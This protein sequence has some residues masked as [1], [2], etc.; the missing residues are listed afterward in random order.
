MKSSARNLEFEPAAFEDLAWWIQR[1]QRTT[2]RILNLLLE[3]RRDPFRGTGKPEAPKGDLSGFW[4]RRIASFT[5]SKRIEL[6]F[7][8]AEGITTET[9]VK[10]EGLFTL[11]AL[12]F[13]VLER[14][15]S[16]C[17]L[18]HHWIMGRK[19]ERHTSLRI[20]AVHHLKQI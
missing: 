13:S 17:P 8:Y 3:F 5:E 15:Q 20:E 1:G 2:R 12:N 4:S 9:T 10:F 19:Y 7:Q 18:H 6:S 11:V 14:Y 16:P